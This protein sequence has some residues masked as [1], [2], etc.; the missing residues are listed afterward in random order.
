MRPP[1][2][3]VPAPGVAGTVAHFVRMTFAVSDGRWSL[4]VFT[5]DVDGFLLRDR[6]S[7]R[8]AARAM[9]SR[10]VGDAEARNASLDDVQ[11]DA[12]AQLVRCDLAESTTLGACS[13]VWWAARSDGFWGSSP[14]R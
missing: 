3:F 13:T 1:P 10:I 11:S 14:A 2:R 7:L 9:L 4:H 6:F 12:G 5:S 8:G